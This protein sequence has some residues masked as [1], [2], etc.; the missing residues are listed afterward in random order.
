MSHRALKRVAQQLGLSSR[1]GHWVN[2][3]D[4][5][6]G[7]AAWQTSSESARVKELEQEV[8]ELRREDEIEPARFLRGGTRPP[9]AQV[10][11]F[12]DQ[13]KDGSWTT[14]GPESSQS[15][16]CCK[17]DASMYYA[18]KSR[19]PSARPCRTQS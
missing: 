19:A 11:A 5:D 6:E 8:R 16:R 12:I 10:V 13:N 7:L 1:S 4:L 15:V 9:T 18:A 3:A 14:G 2:H 17:V